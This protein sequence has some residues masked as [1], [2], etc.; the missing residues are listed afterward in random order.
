MQLAKIATSAIF[1]FSISVSQSFASTGKV[2]LV[3]GNSEYEATQ[4]LRN[5]ANDARAM[6]EK[7]RSMGF[8]TVEGYDLDKDELEDVLDK[9]TDVV[10]DSELALFFYA[11]HG[12]SVDGVN[13]IVPT[14]ARLD[15]PIKWKRAMMPLDDV[16]ETLSYSNGPNLFFMDACR[17]NPMAEQ[18]V[19]ITATANRS[20]STTRGLSRVDPSTGTSGTA[21]AFATSPGKVAS[22][23]DGKHSP[24]TSALLNHLGAPNISIADVMIRVTGA[25]VETTNGQQEPWINMSMTEP[26][27]LNPT[28]VSLTV[29]TETNNIPQAPVLAAPTSAETGSIAVQKFMFEMAVQSGDVSD[30][31]A[32][33]EQFPSGQ[34]SSL[35]KNAITRL[36]KAEVK[37]TETAM[38]DTGTTNI[39]GTV[40]A[41]GTTRTL[42]GFVALPVTQAVLAADAS[43]GAELNLAMDEGARRDV[44]N[45]LNALGHNVGGA[46]GSFGNNTRTG[47]R[48]WQFSQGLLQTGF[49]NTL[50]YQMLVLNSEHVLASYL[51]SQPQST[52]N[53]S[54][55]KR[56]PQQN[57]GVGNAVNSFLHGLGTGIGLRK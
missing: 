42:G 25:V 5:P 47:V 3:I 55:Q 23:G 33:L 49:L 2:A 36:E 43:Q 37:E 24:F 41:V 28:P 46:D 39:G 50:Q 12:I 11:G 7:L 54:T 31:R 18:L 17:D 35:A 48:A 10:V 22:D 40:P 34:F 29:E 56:R 9:F 26:L 15:H 51:A 53:T 1:L 13:Y 32:Y 52:G 38:L 27:M 14:D 16:M 30:F 6:A 21:I 44:Q 57:N 4:S 20:V 19:S 45:R 8:T